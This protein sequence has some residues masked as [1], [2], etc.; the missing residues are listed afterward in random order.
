MNIAAE[1]CDP[2]SAVLVRADCHAHY[3]EG[4]VENCVRSLIGADS[5]SV[6]VSMRAVGHSPLQKA[7]AAAQNSRLGNGGSRHRRQSASGYVEHGH[8]AAFDTATFRS[9]GGYDE[10]APF[11]EDAEFDA[12][13]VRAGG[14][15]YLDGRFVIDYYPRTNFTSLARQ[16]YR[17]GWGRAN[18][19][20]KHAMLPKLRQIL[21]VLVLLMCA[22]A[23]VAWPVVGGVALLPPAAYLAACLVWGLLLAVSVRQAGLLLSGPAAIAMHLSWAL[24]FL[25][26]IAESRMAA[27]IGGSSAFK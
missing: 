14:R 24:G 6:V 22:T 25:K 23:F 4:F 13:L 16:Y 17:H 19:L 12:R 11:N 5:Q 18:T 8:H 20:L 21:P 26:R 2:R 3:P 15:I 9:L 7:I 1:A 10:D 27:M